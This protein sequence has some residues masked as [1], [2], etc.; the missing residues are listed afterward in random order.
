[1][2]VLE[3]VRR[4]NAI[5]PGN[6]QEK[7]NDR[8]QA[9]CAIGE[10]VE[11]EPE[12]VWLFVCRWGDNPL[13]DLRDAIATVLLEHLLEHHFE[14]IFPRVE[15]AARQNPT[16]AD[17]FRRCWKFGQSELPE[18]ANRFDDLQ[19]RCDGSSSGICDA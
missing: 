8:W 16:F 7:N 10:Y 15:A 18:N 19:N 12:V 2:S 3:A 1:M 5:L 13:E 17:M 6:P 4:A 14:L 9:I 11:S